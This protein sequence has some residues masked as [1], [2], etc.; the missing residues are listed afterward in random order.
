MNSAEAL[1]LL[2]P[3]FLKDI[4]QSISRGKVY[5][6]EFFILKKEIDILKNTYDQ[7]HIYILKICM[8]KK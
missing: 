5:I 2:P 3:C 7:W 1:D 8:I 4:I 6:L